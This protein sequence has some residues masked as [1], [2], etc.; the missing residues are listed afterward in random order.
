MREARLILTAPT[1]NQACFIAEWLEERLCTKFGGYTMTHGT[2]GWAAGPAHCYEPIRVYDVAL[3]ERDDEAANELIAL[4]REMGRRAEQRC[5]YL[6][7]PSGEVTMLDIPE[8]SNARG[9]AGAPR[10]VA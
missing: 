8:T 10:M 7:L 9:S 3:D 4:A 1:P 6:R 2:G 5:V